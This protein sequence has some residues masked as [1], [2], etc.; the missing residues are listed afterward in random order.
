[1]RT[2]PVCLVL[3]ACAA[4]KTELAQQAVSASNRSERDRA[5]D[6]HRKPV[7]MLAFFGTGPGMRVAE[8]GAGGG[9]STELFARVVG[10]TGAVFA[11]DTPNWDPASLAKAWQARLAKPEM[12]NTTHFTHQWDDPFPPEVSDLDA[13]YSVA[14][15]HDCINEKSDS[16]KMNAV[17]FN[18][19]KHG[20]VYGIIDNSA[21]D[22]TGAAEV[23]RLHRI[24]EQ[25][26]KAEVLAAGFQL[27]GESDFLRNPADA[28]DWNANSDVNK[29]H[30]Q[31]LFALKFV[32]P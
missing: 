20:G 5:K 27:A 8:I 4:P 17:I 24:D 30:T 21:K 18:A 26:V 14:V 3:A 2:L 1:M 28:R 16:K 10:P 12:K 31:D 19:L 11:L 9:Y 15:Y 29:A 22:G 7:A 32:K 6:E 25:F 23:G 13:V